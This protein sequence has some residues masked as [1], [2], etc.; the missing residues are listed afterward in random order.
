MF[1]EVALAQSDAFRGN[2]HQLVVFDELHAVLQ[3]Q[4]DRR[5]DLDRI[6]LATDAEVGQLLGARGIDHQVVIAA[7][8]TDD[9]ALVH[10]VVGPDKHAAAIVELAQRV[11]EDLA[12][13]HGNEHAV[14]AAANVAF[15]RLIAVENV[16]DQARTTGEVEE[17]IGKADQAA[18]RNAVFQAHAAPAVRLHVHQLALALAQGLHHAALVGFFDVGRHHLNGL[19]AHAIDVTKHHARLGDGQ[20]V[21]FAA[22]VFQQDGQVQLAPTHDLEDALFIGFLHAQGH[23]VLQLLLQAIPKLATGHVLAFAAGQ[24]AGVDAKI[25]GQGGLV[26]LEHGQRRGAGHVGDG[27]AD[28]DVGKAVD[29]HNIARAGLGNLHAVQ[30]LEGQHLID[31]ALDGFAVGAFH[32]HHLLH[33]LDGALAD[34]AHANAAHKGGKVQRRNLQ[35]QGCSRVTVLGR[36]VLE[37]GVEQGRHVRSPLLTGCALGQR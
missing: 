31:A 4:L 6:F 29:Q 32:H 24:R 23:V 27:H 9:H 7:M 20:L 11:G 18:R 12:V 25:H 26:D 37:H 33:G 28:A 14:L 17:F 34:A 22:H 35:L 36:Y 13:V 10:R 19:V 21:A 15:V 16:G 3:R 30:T 1:L 8:N 5:G 2:F